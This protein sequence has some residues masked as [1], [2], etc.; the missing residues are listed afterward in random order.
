MSRPLARFFALLL[1][2]GVVTTP[3]GR[4]SIVDDLRL[5]NGVSITAIVEPGGEYPIV[6]SRLPTLP[7]QVRLL[8]PVVATVAKAESSNAPGAWVRNVACVG[9]LR[10][11]ELQALLST[12]LL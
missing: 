7:A 3:T 1:L 8:L 5:E 12:F 2:V 4:H 6:G 9:A 11:V 10:D